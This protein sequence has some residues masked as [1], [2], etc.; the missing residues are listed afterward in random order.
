M[1][2]SIPR[3]DSR[4]RIAFDEY[5]LSPRTLSGLVRGRPGPLALTRK[6]AI[7]TGNIG[8]SPGLT[9][10]AHYDLWH[11]VAV[12]EMMNIGAQSAA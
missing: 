5:A 4:E 3:E 6:C 12:D 7:R 2:A 9:W 8:A 10:C 1:I 11:P